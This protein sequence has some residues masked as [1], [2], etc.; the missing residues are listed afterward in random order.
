MKKLLC[1]LAFVMAGSA[2]AQVQF[3]SGSA[4]PINP[5]AATVTIDQQQRLRPRIKVKKLVRCRDGS[6][7]RVARSCKYHGGVRR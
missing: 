6:R 1:M 7:Q 5:G 4:R 2:Q 3:E